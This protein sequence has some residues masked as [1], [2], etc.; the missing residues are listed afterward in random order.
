MIVNTVPK[1]VVS[2]FNAWGFFAGSRKKKQRSGFRNRVRTDSIYLTFEIFLYRWLTTAIGCLRIL[3][4][5]AEL[6]SEQNT[7][8]MRIVAF[9][10]SVYVPM[11]FRIHLNP[12]AP[13]GLTNIMLFLRDLLDFEVKE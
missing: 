10:I 11:F 1:V 5:G 3:F 13:E 7:K 12:R 8:L 9:I 4:F 6:D 2:G